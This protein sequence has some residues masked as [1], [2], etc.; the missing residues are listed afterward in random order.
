LYAH[1]LF[2]SEPWYFLSSSHI[3]DLS[4]RSR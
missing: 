1:S 2:L 4:R 3:R